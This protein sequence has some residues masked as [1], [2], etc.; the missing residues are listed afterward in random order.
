MGLSLCVG[1][2]AEIRESDPEYVEYFG[3]QVEAINE[4]LESFGLAPHREPF[5][6]EDE[7]TFE[8]ELSVESGLHLLRRVAA[9]LALKGELPPPGDEDA[10]GDAVL[11][12]YHRIFDTAFAQGH[13]AEMP[14]Q[15]LIVHSDAEGF[16]VPVEFDAVI[17]T[18]ASQEIE[19][20]IVGSTHA[21]LRECREVAAA[22]DV[23]EGL[24]FDDEAVLDAVDAQGEEEEGVDG[25][26]KWRRYGVET[27]TCLALVKACEASIETG[28][29]VVFA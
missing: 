8:C 21:L 11:A 16:Y 1:V 25:E 22:L 27:H 7:R 19:G 18:E 23:P 10:A 24:A 17:I 3:Q 26:P 4:V 9:H 28:A 13:G 29:A 15:H 5:D 12:D 14:F 2:P 6:V 20:G